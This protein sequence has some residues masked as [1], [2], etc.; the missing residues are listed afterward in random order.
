MSL[1]GG[2]ANTHLRKAQVIINDTARWVM[3][4]S[5]RSK[6]S[7]LMEK[8]G[9]LDVK[10]LQ[11]SPGRWSTW[12]SQLRSKERMTVNNDLQI[13]VEKPRLLFT[14]D[15]FRWR[16]ARE[17]K[18]IPIEI[19]Q[20]GNVANFKRQLKKWILQKRTILPDD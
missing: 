11:Y 14:E 18:D 12:T 1:W 16:Y 17:W 4:M 13:Q 7:T 6:V 5:K 19:R 9:W 10:E 8:T 15:C 2:A 20:I 3:G